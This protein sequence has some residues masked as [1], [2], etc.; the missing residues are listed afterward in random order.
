MRSSPHDSHE[1]GPSIMFGT[2]KRALLAEPDR[3]RGP[4]TDTEPDPRPSWPR[5][6][7]TAQ[8]KP[9]QRRFSLSAGFSKTPAASPFP[10]KPAAVCAPRQSRQ[11]TDPLILAARSPSLSLLAQHA[12]GPPGPP[13]TAGPAVSAAPAAA[14]AASSSSRQAKP[15]RVPSRA[16]THVPVS[17]GRPPASTSLPPR[18]HVSRGIYGE[19]SEKG[20]RRE[21][22]TRP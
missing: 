8:H 12:A 21:S 11:H 9:L 17:A 2:K 4:L 1:S 14:A 3:R 7:P 22:T 20:M 10:G 18:A 15:P 19:E 16:F 5:P 6:G 13:A